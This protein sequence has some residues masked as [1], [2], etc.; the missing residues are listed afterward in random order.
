MQV[1]KSKMATANHLTICDFKT[2]VSGEVFGYHR[3]VLWASYVA[4]G[5]LLIYFLPEEENKLITF[6]RSVHWSSSLTP[7]C[8]LCL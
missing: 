4:T 7:Q 8:L 6:H 3:P 2:A 5:G 1:S